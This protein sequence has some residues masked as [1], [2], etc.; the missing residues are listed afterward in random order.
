[1]LLEKKGKK[2]EIAEMEQTLQSIKIAEGFTFVVDKGTG[3]FYCIR[4]G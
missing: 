3:M 1:M 4:H 2:L